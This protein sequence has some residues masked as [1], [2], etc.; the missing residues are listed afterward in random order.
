MG[1]AQLRKLARKILKKTGCRVY[2]GANAAEALKVANSEAVGIELVIVPASMPLPD[3]KSDLSFGIRD[4]LPA[5][6]MIITRSP[7]G[8]PAPLPSGWVRVLDMPFWVSSLSTS[9]M[10]SLPGRIVQPGK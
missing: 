8:D 10:E 7:D 3:A 6:R 9:V 5:V 2:P 1:D 4:I